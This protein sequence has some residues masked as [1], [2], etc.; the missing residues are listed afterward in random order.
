MLTQNGAAG[1]YQGD[2]DGNRIASSGYSQGGAGC[3]LAGRDPRFTVTLPVAPFI[4]LPL[5]G[6]DPAAVGAQTHPMF[7]ISGSADTVAAPASNQQPIFD[8]APVP[9]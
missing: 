7:M 1:P 9:I 3:L 6:Y 8:Q 4:V 2:T 5:G